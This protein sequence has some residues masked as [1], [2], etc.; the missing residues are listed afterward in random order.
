MSLMQTKTKFLI[1]GVVILS[2]GL[3]VGFQNFDF[4]RKDAVEDIVYDQPSSGTPESLPNLIEVVENIQE[5]HFKIKGPSRSPANRDEN[6]SVGLPRNQIASLGV[7]PGQ[8]VEVEANGTVAP[9]IVY[10]S[11]DLSDGAKVSPAIAS[12]LKIKI[13]DKITLRKISETVPPISKKD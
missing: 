11:L 8:K 3:F 7:A 1:P 12:K 5:F 2:L 9:A 10:A 6:T 13:G 4:L